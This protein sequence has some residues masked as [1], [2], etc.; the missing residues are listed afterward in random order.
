MVEQ[1]RKAEPFGF[2][3]FF[4]DG[5]CDPFYTAAIFRVPAYSWTGVASNLKFSLSF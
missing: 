2:S 1:A 3:I 5:Y 4:E